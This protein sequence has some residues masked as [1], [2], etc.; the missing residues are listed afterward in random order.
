MPYAEAGDERP[1]ERT[2]RRSAFLWEC[3]PSGRFTVACRCRATVR[4]AG[5]QLGL[6]VPL[7]GY[8][9]EAQRTG[10][11]DPQ[12]DALVGQQVTQAVAEVLVDRLGGGEP[13]AE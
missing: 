1:P 10:V 9:A 11:Q 3:D 2:A 8:V 12:L 4:R 7:V 6:P 5:E 13:A